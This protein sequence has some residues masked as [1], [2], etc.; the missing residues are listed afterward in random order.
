MKR[1]PLIWALVAGTALLSIGGHA[2]Q[3]QDKLGL[4]QR[5]ADLERRLAELEST[6]AGL[7]DAVGAN[8]ASLD[9]FQTY[10]Q[11]QAKGAAAMAKTLATSESQGFTAGINFVSRET[12]LSGWREFLAIA[13]EGIP[14]AVTEEKAAAEEKG[15][16]KGKQ[17]VGEER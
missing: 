6:S 9:G 10:V 17:P 4:E 16:G 1:Y 2:Q 13:Q 12:L 11:R 5:V 7:R 14:S 8:T 15:K 3:A